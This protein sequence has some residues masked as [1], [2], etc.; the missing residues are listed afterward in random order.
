ML[1]LVFGSKYCWSRRLSLGDVGQKDD[2]GKQHMWKAG[3][4]TEVQDRGRRWN[5]IYHLKQKKRG[6][7]RICREIKRDGEGTLGEEEGLFTG[8]GIRERREVVQEPIQHLNLGNVP[9]ESSSQ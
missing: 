2:C 6:N 4:K 3:I 7:K 8:R 1:Y 9:P 5:Q